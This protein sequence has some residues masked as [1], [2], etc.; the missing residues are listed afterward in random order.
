MKKA[1]K[2]VGIILGSIVGLLLI[3]LGVIY[4][5]SSSNFGTTHEVQADAITIPSDSASL[6]RGQHLVTAIAKCADCH[7]ADFSGKVVIDEPILGVL[8]GPNLTS[9]NGGIGKDYTDQDWIRAIRYGV[10]KE[11]VGLKLMPSNEYWYASDEELGA[12]IAY[13]KSVPPVD[14]ES[15][16]SSVG[17]LGRLLYVT[18]TLPLVQVENIDVAGQRPAVPVPAPSVEYGKHL[19]YVGGCVGCHGEDLAGGPIPGFPP[20]W[21]PAANLT[22]DL[23]GFGGRTQADFAQTLR[24]GI[25]K[26]GTQMN[27][28]YM[29]WRSASQM[30][31]DEITALWLYMQSLPAKKSSS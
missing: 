26:D 3:A 4:I 19:A 1:L 30:Y 21:P 12:I 14:A 13:I 11:G 28:E 2:W 6:A 20:D 17:P 29:P 9:G 8:V 10:N 25:K 18:G 15:K 22:R 16:E 24:T 31:D 5:W 27:N 23:E 7:G